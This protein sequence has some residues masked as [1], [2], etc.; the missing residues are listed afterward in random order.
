VYFPELQ[1]RLGDQQQDGHKRHKA[2]DGI[3]ESVETLQRNE[4]N[5]SQ[6]RCCAHEVASNGESVLPSCN[7]ASRG[8]VSSRTTGVFRSPVGDAEG[9]GDE[10]QKNGQGYR[11]LR[12]LPM[13]F[14]S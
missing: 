8:E 10:N 9:T 11:H 14:R 4:A 6:K 5:D 12:G 1:Q 2:A 7:L 13:S 3:K